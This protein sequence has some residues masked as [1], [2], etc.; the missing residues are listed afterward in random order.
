LTVWQ[1]WLP[2][3]HQVA[4][5]PTPAE[6]P[7]VQMQQQQQRQPLKQQQRGSKQ[8]G[9]AIRADVKRFAATSSMMEV[10]F[11]EIRTMETAA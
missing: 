10:P 1:V 3:P 11:S 7:P 9:H 5:M 2:L 8:L 6:H 4:A